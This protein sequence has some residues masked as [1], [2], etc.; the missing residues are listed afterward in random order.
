MPISNLDHKFMLN[1]IQHIEQGGNFRI[2]F[3]DNIWDIIWNVGLC[4][5]INNELY[6]SET[7][8]IILTTSLYE[9]W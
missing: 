3:C 7:F 4:P 5:V 6:W 9:E 8:L 2:C 1:S